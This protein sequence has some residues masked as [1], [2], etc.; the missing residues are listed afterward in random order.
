MFYSIYQEWRVIRRN[1]GFESTERNKKE[2]FVLTRIKEGLWMK[3]NRG[4]RWKNEKK[5]WHMIRFEAR[6]ES[7]HTHPASCDSNFLFMLLTFL[8]S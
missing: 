3:Q 4:Y 1:G 7:F 6:A 5:I 8:L 2:N